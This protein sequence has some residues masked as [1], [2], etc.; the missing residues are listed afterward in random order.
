MRGLCGALC[1]VLGLACVLNLCLQPGIR[2]PPSLQQQQ[3]NNNNNK[4]VFMTMFFAMRG[5]A[6]ADPAIPSIVA[7]GKAS[8][9]RRS[10]PGRGLPA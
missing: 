1:P 8:Q 6:A 3:N 9:R 5:L 7:G 2:L 4:K 10:F